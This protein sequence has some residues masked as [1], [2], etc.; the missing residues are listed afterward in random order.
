MSSRSVVDNPEVSS[1]GEIVYSGPVSAPAS[2]GFE[3]HFRPAE[4]THLPEHS[5]L[6]PTFTDLHLHS[7][8]YLYAGTGLDLPLMNWLGRYA[9]KAKTRVDGD[10]AL[11]EAVYRRLGERLLENG[12]SAAFVRRSALVV[13]GQG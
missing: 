5:F 8:Q 2:Y 3:A 10:A 6:L 9:F 11:A 1:E 13:S 4:V 7:A 12:T